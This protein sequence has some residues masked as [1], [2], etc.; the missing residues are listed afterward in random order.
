M[1]DFKTHYDEKLY[2]N[3]TDVISD[4]RPEQPVA[5]RCR[6]LK[7]FG[8]KNLDKLSLDEV[9]ALES[10]YCCFFIKVILLAEFHNQAVY[11]DQRLDCGQ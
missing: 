6:T 10:F 5:Q 9:G 3:G 1:I 4:L 7:E 11:G 8:E 2:F